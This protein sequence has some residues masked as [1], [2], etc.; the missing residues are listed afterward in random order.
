MAQDRVAIDEQLK[1]YEIISPTISSYLNYSFVFT[2][3]LAMA[4]DRHSIIRRFP[5]PTEGLL[6][7]SL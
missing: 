1:L 3:V 4:I 6:F 5:L 2:G 7:I